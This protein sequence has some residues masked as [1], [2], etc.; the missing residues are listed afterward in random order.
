MNVLEFIWRMSD[1]LIWPIV[2]L[3]VALV[4][5]SWITT[6]VAKVTADTQVSKVNIGPLGVELKARLSEAARNVANA[7]EPTASP[8][9]N[10]DPVPTNL[11]D[12][13]P[14]VERNPFG[15]INMA[16]RQVR[17]ALDQTY[18]SLRYVDDADL[19]RALADLAQRG[20][21]DREV[22]WAVTH[23][24]QLLAMSDERIDP[25][26]GY[27]FLTLAEGA[28][29][30]ILRRAQLPEQ[31]AGGKGLEPMVRTWRGR[32]MDSY[33]V[34][35][36]IDAQS[37][38]TFTGTMSYPGSGTVTGV[39]GEISGWSDARGKTSAQLRWRESGYE[40][41]GTREVDFEG[42]YR[43]TMFGD[44]LRGAWFSGDREIG[45]FEMTATY[46]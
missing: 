39:A 2:V 34:E 33:E 43:A 8:P 18:P 10:D 31:R 6:L 11:V 29:H 40:S 14:W 28:I 37:G 35:L 23:L 4:Y 16:F 3:T 27:Q 41:R 13:I 7:L 46:R 25:A 5:R 20:R 26:S 32:Y 45:R 15:G 12:L 1:M 38:N 42:E 19:P 24:Y 36:I 44:R 22:E 17:R 30:A 21:I 9:D